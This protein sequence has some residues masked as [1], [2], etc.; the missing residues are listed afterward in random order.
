MGVKTW[1]AV[2]SVLAI[3]SMAGLLNYTSILG[4]LFDL[5][6][7]NYT[8]TGDQ[9]CG[10]TCES[11]IN[12]TSSYWRVCFANYS[13]TKYENDTLFKKQALSRT[14]HLNTAN[15]HTI[16]STKPEVTVD[17]MV[18]A[19]GAGNWR[20]LKDGDCWEINKPQ[21][22]KLVGHKPSWLTVKWSFS[23]TEGYIE[24]DPTW[25]GSGNITG[26][27]NSTCVINTEFYQVTLTEGV[28][29]HFNYTYL[30]NY[31]WA[32]GTT[33]SNNGS[34]IGDLLNST[35]YLMSTGEPNTNCDITNETD[36]IRVNCSNNATGFSP[37]NDWRFYNSYIYLNSTAQVAHDNRFAVQNR[38]DLAVWGWNGTTNNT[39]PSSLTDWDSTTGT[40]A[41][42][43]N[44][45]VSNNIFVVTWDETVT[46]DFDNSE[47]TASNR[48]DNAVA[49]SAGIPSGTANVYRIKVIPYNA[50]QSGTAKY[51]QP[52]Q[53]FKANPLYG[54][55]ATS[56]PVGISYSGDDTNGSYNNTNIEHRLYWEEDTGTLA[57]Y[58]FSFANDSVHFVNDSYVAFG[59]TANWSNVTKRINATV[60][61]TI[62]WKVYA[63]ST[64]N[65]SMVVSDTYSYTVTCLG[66]PTSFYDLYVDGDDPVCADGTAR[67]VA[68][69]IATPW[70]T[71][72]YG[73]DNMAAGDY[74]HIRGAQYRANNSAICSM[75]DRDFSANLTIIGGY[76]GEN[77]NITGAYDTWDHV[78]VAWTSL[79]S[80]RWRTPA[81]GW[82]TDTGCAW[83]AN[84]TELWI[85]DTSAEHLDTAKMINCFYDSNYLYLRLDSS[86]INPNNVPMAIYRRQGLFTFDNVTGPLL[87]TNLTTEWALKHYYIYSGSRDIEIKNVNTTGQGKVFDIR[88]SRLINV[89]DSNIWMKRTHDAWWGPGTPGAYKGSKSEDWGNGFWMQGNYEDNKLI[90][91]TITG[92]FNGFIS[93]E[94][95]AGYANRLELRG[96]RIIDSFD[97]GMEFEDFMYHYSVTGNNVTDA[98]GGLSFAPANSSRGMSNF[99]GNL[100]IAK[101]TYAYS[102]KTGGNTSGKAIKLDN[103]ALRWTNTSFH[104]NTVIGRIYGDRLYTMAN[105]S[106][107]ENIFYSPYGL[108][109]SDP[110]GNHFDGVRW[111]YNIYYC[112]GCA[113]MFRYWANESDTSDFTSLANAKASHQDAYLWDNHSNQTDPIFQNESFLAWVPALN[114]PA[115]NMSINGSYIG[116]FPCEPPNT[117]ISFNA[118]SLFGP[119]LNG[120]NGTLNVE[121]GSYVYLYANSSGVETVCLDMNDSLYGQ[122]FACDEQE[123]SVT[124]QPLY[125]RINQF[126]DSTTSKNLSF[127]GLSN[128]TFYIRTHG[129]DEPTS[130]KF[131]L[132]GYINGTYPTELRIFINDSLA[133]ELGSILDLSIDYF[134]G[135]NQTVNITFDSN[136]TIVGTSL[137]LPKNSLATYARFNLT[138]HAIYFEDTLPDSIA[139]SGEFLDNETYGYDDDWDTYTTAGLEG[140][141]LIYFNYSKEYNAKAT[142]LWEVKDFT[143]TYNLTPQAAC[144]SQNPVR[145]KVNI[146]DNPT[147]ALHDLTYGDY[148]Y[149][150]WATTDSAFNHYPLT[151]PQYLR[152]RG[153]FTA[154]YTESTGTDL[155]TYSDATVSVNMYR[156]SSNTGLYAYL[157]C[158]GG[159]T[160][161]QFACIAYDSAAFPACSDHSSGIGSYVTKS[162]NITSYCGAPLPSNFKVRFYG[163]GGLSTAEVRATELYVFGDQNTD[164]EYSC[165]NGTYVSLLNSSYSGLDSNQY[166]R[167]YEESLL[168]HAAPNNPWLEVGDVNGTRDRNYTGQFENYTNI[169]NDLTGKI[170]EY[171]EDCEADE[172]GNC[173]LPVTL[174]SDS[175]G[176]IFLKN[177]TINYS[178]I[179]NPIEV[180]TDNFTRYLAN[181][182]GYVDVPIIIESATTGILQI[183]DLAY[184]HKGGNQSYNI[185]AHNADYSNN[186]SNTINFYY[187]GWNYKMPTNINYVEF[188]PQKPTSKNVTPFGQTS[189]RPLLNITTKNYGGLSMNFSMLQNETFGCVE[190]TVSTSNSKATGTTM[191]ALTWETLM[192][193]QAFLNSTG[194]WFWA[195][196]DCDYTS[197]Y[198]WQPNWYFRGC[199]D[200]CVCAEEVT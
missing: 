144:L 187:S 106:F 177:L 64:T 131:N 199:C 191:S 4:N 3:I 76:P 89:T 150:N 154:Y 134:I 96:N 176:A 67:S 118:T 28:I 196:Y 92:F 115:C 175:V 126:N 93:Y 167:F 69:N 71:I 195:D 19:V 81:T 125:F 185:T 168:W 160:W 34:N 140:N 193:N 94:T 95:T 156:T 15:L 192:A 44:T 152:G 182:S 57:G 198:M 30:E 20:P 135:Y 84:K 75:A 101:R 25:Y 102:A 194:L 53:A 88:G 151:G 13:G 47:S 164:M 145:F 137:Y 18:P 157:S 10:D 74:L 104:H 158:N 79:G 73:C 37:K 85:A 68:H 60:G 189:T 146:T 48:V 24:I 109:I 43:Y 149:S 128:Q 70:C 142:T 180:P 188:I 173:E 153:V 38:L 111:D 55:P 112:L 86:A 110:S 114:S 51:T 61:A 129:Y 22:L 90:N 163:Q 45:S 170:N 72:D 41:V 165:Y 2:A 83:A 186:Q 181:Y 113:G 50:S 147:V 172:L 148:D 184:D 190:L 65:T 42:S 82:S 21:K 136:S 63:N 49:R 200:N 161:T 46:T 100:L 9:V 166:A 171:L 120:T 27:C 197:W 127:S 143:G 87:V 29:N 58:I 124:I 103:D 54:D 98:V 139:I 99:T 122:N 107:K 183:N 169:S 133:K 36:Y 132:T 91:N 105:N 138:G 155:S 35:K 59:G 78:N 17:L 16:V 80:Y 8:Y 130:L 117:T 119:Y 33:T 97:D 66:C 7:M 39:P 62:S 5:K 179:F 14:L 6:G 108:R 77:V 141:A 178:T 31:D 32:K 1:Q 12:V 26:S 40:L 11:Y 159:S 56:A 23:S 116:A 162:V 52:I 174:H 123:V 121:L